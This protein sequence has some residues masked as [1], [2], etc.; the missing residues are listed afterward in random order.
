MIL[1]DLQNTALQPNFLQLGSETPPECRYFLLDKADHYALACLDGTDDII[2]KTVKNLE[3]FQNFYP[4]KKIYIR[5]IPMRNDKK[6]ETRRVFA[7]EVLDLI[8]VVLRQQGIPLKKND[9]RL[10]NYHNNWKMPKY[11]VKTI[12]LTEFSHILEE[13]ERFKDNLGA[14]KITYIWE[15]LEKTDEQALFNCIKKITSP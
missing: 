4:K 13:F 6:D 15:S 11:S 8:P 2:E 14:S 10:N 5:A 9:E 3:T 1:P 12:S 7:E